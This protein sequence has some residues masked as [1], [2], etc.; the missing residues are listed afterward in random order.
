MALIDH[1]HEDENWFE[2][3]HIWEKVANWVRFH[4]SEADFRSQLK[5]L[6]GLL[7]NEKDWLKAHYPP[8]GKKIE[9]FI[10]ASTYLC[11]IADL[12]NAI[13]HRKLTKTPRSTS[14]QTDYY[15]R[16]TTGRG[17]TRRMYFINDGK[18]A[19]PEIMEIL[20]GAIDE[21]EELRLLLS[22]GKL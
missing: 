11:I 8:Q 20:R 10:N 13:K 18:G 2:V 19:H 7:W 22:S 1:H 17:A 6:L 15:G 3:L 9:E 12:A 4:P 5:N 14:L 16:L 21:C